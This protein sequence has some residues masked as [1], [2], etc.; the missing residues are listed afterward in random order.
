MKEDA[1][2]EFVKGRKFLDAALGP[3]FGATSQALHASCHKYFVRSLNVKSTFD[4]WG[5]ASSDVS[6][7]GSPR[8]SPTLG[9]GINAFKC[10]TGAGGW[11]PASPLLPEATIRAVS[12][13]LGFNIRARIKADGSD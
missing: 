6:R 11:R 12:P 8:V 1:V 2:L 4:D 10:Q 3:A 7:S 13:L 9:L 5:L